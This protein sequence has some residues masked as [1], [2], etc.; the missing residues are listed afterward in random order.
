[1]ESL[2]LL[3]SSKMYLL[4]SNYYLVQTKSDA[5]EQTHTILCA[6]GWGHCRD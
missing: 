1:M 5:T 4:I 6:Q 3:I 2:N